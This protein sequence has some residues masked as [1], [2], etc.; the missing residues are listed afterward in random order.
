MIEQVREALR[1]LIRMRYASDP[2]DMDRAEEAGA[3]ALAALDGMELVRGGRLKELWEVDG[4]MNCPVRSVC[5]VVHRRQLAPDECRDNRIAYLK[6]EED[7]SSSTP[8][9]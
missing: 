8:G 9:G 7:G 3:T 2:A 1:L 4:C 6:G 5:R